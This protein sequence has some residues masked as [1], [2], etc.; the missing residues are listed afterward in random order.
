VIGRM[1]ISVNFEEF[2]KVLN[3]VYAILSDKSVED[4]VK[5]VIFLVSKNELTLVGYNS[6][7]FS[8]TKLD[9]VECTDISDSGWEF[10]IRAAEINKIM[11]SYSN[12]FKTKVET[13]DIE[14]SGVRIK[15]TVHE[16]PKDEKDY[17]L[18]QDSVFEVENAPIIAKVLSDVKT[19]FPES[20]KSV[21][22]GDLMLYLSSLLPMMSNDT[23]NSTASKLMMSD[24]YIFTMSSSASAFMKNQLSN[25]FKDITLGYSSVGFLKKMCEG[26]EVIS[27]SKTD[28][29]LCIESG[30]TQAFMRYKPIKINYKAYI[31]RRT[32]EKG[33]VVD[34]LYMKDVF[35]RML[36][37]SNDGKMFISSDSSLTVSNDVF[38]Q[39]VPLENVKAGTVGISFKFSVPILSSLILGSDEVFSGDLFIYFVETARSYVIYVQ[40]K[41]GVWFASS[42]ASKL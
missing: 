2:N 40:D 32:K 23:N 8:R 28:K 33:I 18:A 25:E 21:I 27:V 7:T 29:Y 5:N 38:Q 3:Y 37:T 9:N 22:S 20:V 34:R 15:I 13:I 6:F 10:Q 11:L 36:N 35:K 30:N 1:K 39:E 24:D 16:E 42:Q 4:K 19:E 17:K 41:S 12:L 14:D 31:E 26:S